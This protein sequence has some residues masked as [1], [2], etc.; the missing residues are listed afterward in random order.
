MQLLTAAGGAQRTRPCD[1]AVRIVA[2]P[3]WSGVLSFGLVTL[4]VKMYT[5]ADSHVIHFHQLQRGTSDRVRNK[6]VNERTGEDVP[7]TRS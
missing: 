7:L 3:V 1:E 6:R 2:R 5:A 4:P